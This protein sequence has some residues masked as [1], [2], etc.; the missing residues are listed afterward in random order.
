MKTAAPS[1]RLYA[2]CAKPK[3][4]TRQGLI[5]FLKLWGLPTAELSDQGRVFFDISVPDYWRPRR[6][7][8]FVQ[9]L[10]N[11]RTEH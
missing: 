2:C 11:L 4:Q 8:T 6:R 5:D 10:K 7:A 1:A 9:A 3:C